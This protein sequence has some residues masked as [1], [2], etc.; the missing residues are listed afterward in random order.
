MKKSSIRTQFYLVLLLFLCILAGSIM[1]LDVVQF[2]AAYRFGYEQQALASARQAR[3]QIYR[4]LTAFPLEQLPGMSAS[5]QELV[6]TDAALSYAYVSGGDGYILYAWPTEWIGKLA[7]A[8]LFETVL[9]TGDADALTLELAGAYEVLIPL[10]WVDE[11]IAILHVGVSPAA[12][13]ARGSALVLPRLAVLLG[14]LLAGG[15]YW[16]H[17]LTRYIQRPLASLEQALRQVAAGDFA[18]TVTVV[19]EDEVG[20]AAHAFNAMTGHLRG[21]V[22]ELEQRVGE[23]TRDLELRSAQLRAAADVGRAITSILDVDRLTEQVVTLI[24]QRFQM[25][26]V[27]LFLIDEEGKWAV[28]RA[29]VGDEGRQLAAADFRVPVGQ[30]LIGWS[31]LNARS[32][33]IADTRADSI[34]IDV[35]ELPNTRSEV[36]L[37]LRS[38]G[39]VIGA[40]SVQS[41]QYNAFDAEFVNVLQTLADAVAVAIDNARL[42]AHSQE[43]LEI[44]RQAYGELTRRAWQQLLKLRGEWG[45]E[46]EGGVQDL[47]TGGD[48]WDE[49]MAQAQQAGQRVTDAA[50][51]RLAIPI[52]ERQTL[53]GVLGFE[54]AEAEEGWSEDEV[55]LLETLAERLGVA[56]ESAR[57]YQE[58]QQRAARE[59]LIGAVTARIRE[60]LDIDQVMQTAVDQI[61]QA[62][63]LHDALIELGV[64]EITSA[65]VEP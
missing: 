25:Y 38:R 1:A 31:I 61:R 5:L 52:R 40:L 37:P 19:R 39:Q 21:F 3:T 50:T 4:G 15:F 28:L 29:G 60:S 8:R 13:R 26:Y 42:F 34:R 45:Y 27:G 7:E 11:V 20:A 17:W 35:R 10:V 49:T 36:A 6:Q 33:M 24:Q 14:V 53:V 46:Y 56:L 22:A 59:Q 63:G 23:R 65:D 47:H 58:T 18:Q 16:R 44:Q 64:A 12:I 57:S 32:R 43:A 2:Q 41:D 62:F 51:A 54:K 48:V 30:G 9:F 55:A